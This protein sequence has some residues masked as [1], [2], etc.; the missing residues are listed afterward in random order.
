MVYGIPGI[1]VSDNG[2]QCCSEA[3]N[4]VRELV[5]L[6]HSIISFTVMGRQNMQCNNRPAKA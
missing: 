2:L 6:V 1:V 4:G 3:A 5:G